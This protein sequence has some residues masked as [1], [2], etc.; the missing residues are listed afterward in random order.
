MLSAGAMALLLLYS[1]SFPAPVGRDT[2]DADPTCVCSGERSAALIALPGQEASPEGRRPGRSA[3]LW[4]APCLSFP[5]PG[6]D[7]TPKLLPALT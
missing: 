3:Q 2:E 7:C 6:Q 5:H 1:Y 4:L